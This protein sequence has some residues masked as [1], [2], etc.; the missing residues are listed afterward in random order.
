MEIYGFTIP[1]SK[2][3]RNLDEALDIANEI[4]YPIVLKVSSKEIIHKTDVNGV[5]L[6]IENSYELKEKYNKI[7]NNISSKFKIDGILVQQMLVGGK[8]TIL[9]ITLDPNFG[10]LIMFGLGGIY[11][12]ILKDV[13][14]RITPL[15]D[16]ESIEM[17]QAI[18]G[19]P[20]LKGARG[21]KGVDIDAIS[22][23]LQRLSQFVCD[24][25]QVEQM[26]INPF[27][28]FP[29]GKKSIALD[30]RIKINNRI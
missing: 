7:I 9:G 20:I 24:F 8:E 11:V 13:T 2:L 25:H 1:K 30:A 17:I 15:T 28:V 14:F 22:E 3:A 29:D 6:D 23:A 10:P 19:Y 16:V 27:Y 5:M 26:D 12:E 4:G 21:E 18:R